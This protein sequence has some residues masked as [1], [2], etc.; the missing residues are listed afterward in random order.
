[1]ERSAG[2]FEQGHGGTL[3]LDEVG[4]M[5]PTL[6]KLLRVLEDLRVWRLGGRRET[7][8][9]VRVVA[10]TIQEPGTHLR[11]SAECIPNRS[12]AARPQRGY[13]ADRRGHAAESEQEAR[14]AH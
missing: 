11:K 6:P 5:P 14:H 12:A 4:D 13:S 9:D 10:A 2:G 1:M 8:V 7:P 3:F